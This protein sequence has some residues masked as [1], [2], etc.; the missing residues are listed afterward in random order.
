MT[1][2]QFNIRKLVIVDRDDGGGDSPEIKYAF[3]LQARD[4]SVIVLAAR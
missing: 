1:S 3:E 2:F 4:Q